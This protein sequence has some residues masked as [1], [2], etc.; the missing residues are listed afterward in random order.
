MK[1]IK[2][3][4]VFLYIFIVYA[5][6]IKETNTKFMNNVNEMNFRRFM[7]KWNVYYTNIYK[8]IRQES[9]NNCLSFYY[10]FDDSKQFMYKLTKKDNDN[11][12]I[13]KNGIIHIKDLNSNHLWNINDNK[14]TN[15]SQIILYVDPNY[16]LAIISDNKKEKIDIIGRLFNN[17]LKNKEHI[18]Y[19]L[20]NNNLP[21]FDNFVE[22][23]HELCD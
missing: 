5:E 3:I 2:I 21:S 16:R 7:G 4:I 1:T 15:F 6:I 9:K 22:I 23:K 14:E 12:L 11:K 20:N 17:D 19:I 8:P 13:E 18:E 10:Y